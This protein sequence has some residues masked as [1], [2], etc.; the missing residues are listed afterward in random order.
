MID[1][2]CPMLR[3]Y[4]ALPLLLITAVLCSQDSFCQLKWQ[5]VDS[6]FQPLPSSVHVYR[7]TGLLDG[8]PNIAYYVEADMKDRK[9][10]FTTDTTYKR[11]LT[12]LKFY[13]KNKQPLLVI[14][15]TFFSFTTNQNLN[16]VIKNKDV[17]AFNPEL[18]RKS[19]TDTTIKV[20]V[21][22]SAIGI[23]NRRTADIAWI[24]T[25]STKNYAMAMQ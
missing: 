23:S 5:N 3:T 22:G 25:D 17:V 2:S 4:F 1:N 6:L 12:P 16:V 11:R 21:Y 15:T 20:A 10:D 13:E 7:T 19:K 18:F 14:N 24:K 8:K 9:L